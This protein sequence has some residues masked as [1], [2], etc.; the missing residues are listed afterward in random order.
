MSL[1]LFS[2]SI[3]NLVLVVCPQFSPP[4]L[5][6]KLFA[7]GKKCNYLF[8]I[9]NK[10][11]RCCCCCFEMM[12]KWLPT[13]KTRMLCNMKQHMKIMKNKS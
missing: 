11:C 7:G 10:F 9:F 5:V 1:L 13:A 4:R 12:K 6:Y 3:D 8:L 2:P